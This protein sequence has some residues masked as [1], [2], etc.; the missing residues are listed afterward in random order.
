[1]ADLLIMR[2]AKDDEAARVM[3]ILEDGKRSIARFGIEQWQHG[4]P[5]LAGVEDD[6][7]HG[8]CYVAE[9]VDGSLLGTLALCRGADPEYSRAALPW[10]T[11]NPRDGKVPYASVHRCATAVEALKRG[12]MG[13]LF[14]EAGRIA[15]SEGLESLRIDTHP[16]NRAMRSF[17]SKSGFTEIGPF[18]LV[19]KGDTETDLGRIA[20]EKLLG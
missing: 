4:Y 18:Q 8:F 11:D 9:D 3:E 16:G 2:R 17:L 15:R 7:A 19:C 13:F 1:M 5:N 12:V 20:Y 14:A 6:L 10:L